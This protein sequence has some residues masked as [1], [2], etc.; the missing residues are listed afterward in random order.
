MKNLFRFAALSAICLSAFASDGNVAPAFS[1]KL[2][3][4]FELPAQLSSLKAAAPASKQP[5]YALNDR[6]F[7][8]LERF[9]APRRMPN[10]EIRGGFL[11]PIIENSPFA[12]SFITDV[13][14]L[15]LFGND[16]AL[17]YRGGYRVS[18]HGVIYINEGGLLYRKDGSN[19]YYGILSSHHNTGPAMRWKW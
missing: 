6:Q 10:F 1:L 18:P 12:D 9:F 8:E 17:K 5:Q 14:D 19:L 16:I 3:N 2:G 11:S 13:Q 15:L 4:A 7:H